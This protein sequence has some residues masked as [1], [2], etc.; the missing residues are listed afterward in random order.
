MSDSMLQILVEFVFGTLV[1]LLIES[2]HLSSSVNERYLRHMKPFYH[3]LSNYFRFVGSFSPFLHV[4]DPNAE[5]VKELLALIERMRRYANYCITSGKDYPVSYFK[6]EELDY[7]CEDGI[8]NIWYYMSEKYNY[9]IPYLSYDVEK[10]KLL[11]EIGKNYLHEVSVKYDGLE[12]NTSLLMQ[13]SGDF[14]VFEWKPIEN[15]P[16]EY[17]SWT[18]KIHNFNVLT[19]FGVG[20]VTILLLLKLF[21]NNIIPTCV[22]ITLTTISIIFFILCFC[23]MMQLYAISK[24]L[25][26]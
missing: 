11:N 15:Y 6:P 12:W 23:K 22:F 21:L 26:I 18:K 16:T 3:R 2:I 8:N 9:V 17:A 1:L 4:S 24:R 13:V 20:Y 7:I 14:Y 10:A 5:Y 25:F 19:I